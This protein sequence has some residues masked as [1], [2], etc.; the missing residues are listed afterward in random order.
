MP[1]PFPPESSPSRVGFGADLA[2][3]AR[4]LLSQPSVPLVSLALM[5][6][7][8]GDSRSGH[9]SDVR[10]VV[11]IASMFF[12]AGWYGV[13]RVFFQR[14]LQGRPVPLPHLLR[15]V[16]PF[17]GRFLM[18]AFWFGITFLAVFFSLAR[19]IGM[20]FLDP[21]PIPLSLQVDMAAVVIAMDFALTF[22]TPALAYTTRSAWRALGIGFAMIGQTWPRSAL[23]VLCPPLALSLLNYIVPVG[24]AVLHFILTSVLLLI[25]LL[26]KG[27]IAAFYLRERGSYSEDGA[28]YRLS[29]TWRLLRSP[30]R[31]RVR[32]PRRLGLTVRRPVLF[33]VPAVP[34]WRRSV[35]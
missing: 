15:L 2:S 19:V 23:Y 7:V 35:L 25:S 9:D 27:A 8:C 24:G 12:L 21:D 13:E 16:K 22:V 20:D 18:L 14:H 11:G 34:V 4:A 29:R 1:G 3:A 28:A 10:S 17:L 26:A 31:S 32:R 30:P 6:L 33:R 5:L